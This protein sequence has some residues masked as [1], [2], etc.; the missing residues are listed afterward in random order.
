V[1]RKAKRLPPVAQA[2]K[3]FLL[4]DGAALIEQAVG[5]GTR[6]ARTRR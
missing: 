3:S 1:H 2:F 5:A 6:P 4:H